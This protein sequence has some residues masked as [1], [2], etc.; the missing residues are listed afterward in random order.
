MLEVL[1]RLRRPPRY[2]LLENVRGFE[3]SAARD[4][5]LAALRR[6]RLHWRELLLSPSQLGVPNSRS[7]YYLLARRSPFPFCQPPDGQVS[8]T[9][10]PGR[11]WC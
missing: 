7:R 1:P 4:A 6:L 8:T 10:Q 3:R 9:G 5:L 2:I 11:G